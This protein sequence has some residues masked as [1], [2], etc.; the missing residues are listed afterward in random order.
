MQHETLLRLARYIHV[1]LPGLLVADAVHNAFVVHNLWQDRRKVCPLFLKGLQHCMLCMVGRRWYGSLCTCPDRLG[2]QALRHWQEW[3]RED[4]EALRASALR[5]L[6]DVSSCCRASAFWPQSVATM[7]ECSDAAAPQATPEQGVTGTSPAGAVACALVADAAPAHLLCGSAFLGSVLDGA[8][9]SPHA[10]PDVVQSRPEPGPAAPE[11]FAAAQL[12]LFAAVRERLEGFVAAAASRVPAALFS[13]SLS[14][15]GSPAAVPALLRGPLQAAA[16]A[17]GRCE[18]AWQRGRD[19]AC[20]ELEGAATRAAAAAQRV[21][22]LPHMAVTRRSALRFRVHWVGL[23]PP[24]RAA[25]LERM[26][27][28]D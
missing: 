24:P 12:R 21:L 28:S 13:S 7:L 19:A 5:V 10:A 26:L 16:A 2:Q 8:A 20:A 27:P 22:P 23:R 11:T 1:I 4:K 14:Q 6:Q 17:L 18:Q 3:L 25:L 9:G 15:R